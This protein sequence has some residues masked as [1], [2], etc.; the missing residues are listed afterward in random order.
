MDDVVS[1]ADQG[2][3]AFFG[4]LHKAQARRKL[5][6]LMEQN[7]AELHARFRRHL[8]PLPTCNCSAFPWEHQRGLS[9]Q[10]EGE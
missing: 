5:S 4:G 3:A 2:R 6:K 8:D 1:L 7:R 10:C 9:T